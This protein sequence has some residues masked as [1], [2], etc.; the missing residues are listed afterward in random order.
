MASVR[1]LPLFRRSLRAGAL[2]GI[3]VILL[4]PARVLPGLLALGAALEHSHLVRLGFDGTTVR[5]VLS[6]ER[7]VASSRSVA[8]CGA[9]AAG[10]HHGIASR[11]VCFLSNDDGVDPD[12][13]ASFVAGSAGEEVGRKSIGSTRGAAG[14][15][16]DFPFQEFRPANDKSTGRLFPQTH[17]PPRHCACLQLVGTT[18]QLI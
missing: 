6:H 8:G 3:L 17:G 4:G 10:H 1:I 2:L 14:V 7:G 16:Q 9:P 18:V 12:H 5:L 11:F 15:V 13:S